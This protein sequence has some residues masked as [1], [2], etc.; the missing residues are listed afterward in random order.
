MSVLVDENRAPKSMHAV[1]EFPTATQ[2]RTYVSVTVFADSDFEASGSMMMGMREDVEHARKSLNVA[3][4]F[5]NRLRFLSLTY[6][7]CG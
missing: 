6:L 7:T 5:R 3:T 4:S 1:R 2:R